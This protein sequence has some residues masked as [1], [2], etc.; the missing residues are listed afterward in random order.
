MQ[1]SAI[2]PPHIRFAWPMVKRFIEASQRR[3]RRDMTVDEIK[4]LCSTDESWRLLVFEDC[5]GAAVIRVL[6]DRLHV[7]AIGGRFEKGWHHE[8]FDWLKRIAAFFGLKGVTLAGRKGWR[9]LLAPLG[10]VS[11]GGDWLGVDL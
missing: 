9:R 8:F 3:G 6:N 7:V 1:I 4:Y 5:S 11:L 2:E 10:F